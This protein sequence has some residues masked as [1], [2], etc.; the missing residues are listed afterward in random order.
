MVGPGTAKERTKHP[1]VNGDILSVQPLSDFRCCNRQ[2]KSPAL[3]T[4]QFEGWTVRYRRSGFQS[5]RQN[6]QKQNKHFIEG[7]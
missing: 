1:S 4:T 7:G 3:D 6:M 5:L 2:D